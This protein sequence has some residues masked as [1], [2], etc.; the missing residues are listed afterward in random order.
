ML[1]T[2]NDNNISIIL[3]EFHRVVLS[4]LQSKLYE[5]QFKKQSNCFLSGLVSLPCLLLIANSNIINDL[6]VIN[7]YIK[8]TRITKRKPDAVGVIIKEEFLEPMGITNE[9]LADTMHVHRNTVISIVNGKDIDAAQA[10]LLA[11]ALGTSSDFWL[12]LQHEVDLWNA[13]NTKE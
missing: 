9:M 6:D 2:I 8:M 13:A 4:I 7:E 5:F 1:L 12:N 3:S 10:V 11:A